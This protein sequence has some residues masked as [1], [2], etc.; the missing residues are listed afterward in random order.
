MTCIAVTLD[1][2][3][4]TGEL[5]STEFKDLNYLSDDE[6][7]ALALFIDNVET[8]KGLVGK[9]KPSWLD[10]NLDELPHTSSY[11]DLNYWH[12]HSGPD[13]SGSAAK[14]LTYDLKLNL[15]GITSSEVIHYIK[16]SHDSITIVAFTPEHTPFPRSDDPNNTNPLFE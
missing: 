7:E 3:F 12:Y 2:A 14:S 11:K 16:D 1:E 9:N 8:G 10:D 5:N 13:Y 4:T 6:M 15:N